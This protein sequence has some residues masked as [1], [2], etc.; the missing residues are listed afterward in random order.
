MYKNKIIAYL[1]KIIFD[2]NRQR[3][4]NIIIFPSHL[5]PKTKYQRS[6]VNKYFKSISK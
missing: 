2:R 6:V 3:K 5:V 4:V 1:N